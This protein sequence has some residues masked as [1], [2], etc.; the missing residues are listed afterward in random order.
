MYL[1]MLLSTGSEYF[2]PVRL[3][4]EDD[5]IIDC[6]DIYKRPA[7]DDPLLKNHM[8]EVTPYVFLVN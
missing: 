2:R 7:F 8:I 1:S 3:Q 4:S 6:V 5:D